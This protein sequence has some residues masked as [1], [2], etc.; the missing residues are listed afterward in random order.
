MRSATRTVPCLFVVRKWTQDNHLHISRI[1][2]RHRCHLH[3]VIAKH[4]HSMPPKSPINEE[5]EQNTFQDPTPADNHHRTSKDGKIKVS[6]PQT[7]R[8]TK[9]KGS[10]PSSG[11]N[12]SPGDSSILPSNRQQ[13]FR[14]PPS[15]TTLHRDNRPGNNSIHST[16]T[17]T[18]PSFLNSQWRTHSTQQTPLADTEG[19]TQALA[20]LTTQDNSQ[21]TA[22][23]TVGPTKSR[24]RTAKPRQPPTNTTTTTPLTT[25]TPF[26]NP[27]TESNQRQITTV[28]DTPPQQQRTSQKKR[29]MTIGFLKL[30]D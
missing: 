21:D 5:S 9:Q 23:S 19:L 25:K 16:A 8:N 17:S 29:G 27:N 18:R 1:L 3:N 24:W 22:T 6:R 4:H 20:Q 28:T 12:S 2:G 26:H 13:P 7:G 15:R 11:S 14:K 10:G 30:E